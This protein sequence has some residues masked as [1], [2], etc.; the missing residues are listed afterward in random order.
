MVLLVTLGAILQSAVSSWIAA[1]S[2]QVISI[3]DALNK[4]VETY[5]YA[6]WQLYNNVTVDPRPLDEKIQEIRLRQDIYYLEKPRVKTEALIFGTHDEATLGMTQQISRFLDTL[7]GG[8][9]TLGL[10][11]T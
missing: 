9:T 6:T 10:C 2:E 3:A 5:R 4:R 11:T 1:K 7:W 8:K